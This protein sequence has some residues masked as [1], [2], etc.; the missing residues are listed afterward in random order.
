M[1][2]SLFSSLQNLE[3]IIFGLRIKKNWPSQ[4]IVFVVNYLGKNCT[5]IKVL[6]STIFLIWFYQ[7]YNHQNAFSD[8]FKLES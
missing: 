8:L 5:I 2:F 7:Q 1:L 4:F 3:D 6:T